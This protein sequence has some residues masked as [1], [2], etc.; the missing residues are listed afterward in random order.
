MRTTNFERHEKWFPRKVNVIAQALRIEQYW[1]MFS[2]FPMHD[3]GWYIARSVMS[4]GSEIDLITGKTL[5]LRKP[6]R[7][8]KLYPNQRWRKYSMNLRRDSHRAY[9][10]G[11]VRWLIRQHEDSQS[12]AE[13]GPTLV[14]VRLTYMREQTLPD[15]L[16]EAIPQPMPLFETVR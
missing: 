11:Y 16:A 12:I 8:A 1:S 3:D 14:A 15:L 9:R 10:A 2:P 6:A 4:D 7:V 5:D 13:R